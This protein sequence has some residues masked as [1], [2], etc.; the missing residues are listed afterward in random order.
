M[1]KSLLVILSASCFTWPALA[2]SPVTV[3]FSY[4]TPFASSLGLY[5]GPG[6]LGSGTYW[7]AIYQSA[8]AEGTFTNQTSWADDGRTA[9]GIQL[10]V[11]T[12]WSWGTDGTI[13]LL[14]Q[15]AF[16]YG[17]RGAKNFAFSGIPNGRYDLV[18]FGVNGSYRVAATI[19]TIG[20]VSENTTNTTDAAFVL[21]DN[22]VIFRNLKVTDGTIAGTYEANLNITSPDGKSEGDF[23]GA[24]L[25]LVDGLVVY[26]PTASPTN[27]VFAGAPVTLS[28]VAGSSPIQYQWRKN[29]SPINGATASSLVFTNAAATDSGNYDVEVSNSHGSTI[30]PALTFSV[31]PA[32]APLFTLQPAS[33]SR[34]LHQNVTFRAAVEG[35]QPIA[36]QWKHGT[37]DIPGATNATLTINDI[38]TSD[39]GTYTLSA[40][41]SVDSTNSTPAVLT[42]LSSPAKF[43][44]NFDFDSYGTQYGSATPGTYSG[45]G[46]LGTGTFWN[47]IPQ[48]DNGTG[49]FTSTNSLADDGVT[50]T[51]IKLSV[52]TDFSWGGGY[53]SSL[54]DD[55]ATAKPNLKDLIFRG[56]PDGIYTLVLFGVNGG[57]GSGINNR[58]TIFTFNGLSLS[59]L[60][61]T[62]TS[63]IEGDTYVMFSDLRVTGGILSGTYAPNPEA[64]SGANDEGDFCG[65]QLQLVSG[66]ASSEV[67]LEIQRNASGVLQLTWPQGKLLEASRLS[68]PWTTNNAAS[69]PYPVNPAQPGQFY[70]ILVQ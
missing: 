37:S 15:Y 52:G 56:V 43:T 49:T 63:F 66:I 35:T 41:N 51:G 28:V 7:N 55:Y 3:N 33:A 68:G 6:V 46:V 5:H 53:N 21:N 47:S 65:A 62:D 8:G 42:L 45:P 60:N 19:F 69:S 12:I 59:T 38:K 29:G 54:L 13:P 25:V 2:Q 36:L 16:T 44:I 20:G 4:V 11:D 24:Q 58:G 26:A 22:Y 39:A 48:P 34:F 31:N 23:N 50:D 70:Q 57:S 67:R 64:L 40:S 27:T 32:S 10:S 17:D 9:T 18:L 14:A 30:S 1:K 61:T